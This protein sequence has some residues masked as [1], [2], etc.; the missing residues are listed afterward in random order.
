[1]ELSHVLRS[2]HSLSH[3][4]VDS[5]GLRSFP[6]R[7]S[8]DLV[9]HG[10]RFEDGPS[11]VHCFLPFKTGNRVCHHAGASLDVQGVVLDHR[12]ADGDGGVQ[13]AVERQVTNSAAVY[14][15]LYACQLVD[16]LHRADFRGAAEGARG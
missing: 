9:G 1:T 8:S 16:Y 5:R 11:L 2:Y 15:T 3:C 6:T 12:G 7:R 13:V 14:T 4:Y 10:D